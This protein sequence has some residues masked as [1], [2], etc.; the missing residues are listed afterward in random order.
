M[1]EPHGRHRR[2]ET[3]VGA[4]DVLATSSPAEHTGP[5]HSAAPRVRRS[6]WDRRRDRV[7]AALLVVAW[8]AAGVL[9]WTFSDSRATTQET[10][11]PPPALPP[12][13]E[14][15]PDD[16]AEVWRAPSDATPVPVAEDSAVVAASD[17]EV[18]G[19]DPLTGEVRWR[20]A[21]DLQLCTVAGAWSKAVAVYRKD[22]GCSEVTQ[23]D[24]A[25]G[26]RTAQRNGDAELGT[27][28]VVGEGHVT[29]TGERLLNTWRD[30][31][32][33]SMEYGRVPA[34]VNPDRQP[35]TGCV[36]DSVAAGAGKVGVVESCPRETG[37]RLTV[38]KA[39]GE[40]A[41]EPESEF[42]TVL[43]ERGAQLVAMS[44]D[45][46]AVA[47]P[48]R[49]RLVVYDAEG[50]Q[51]A[52]YPLEVPDSDLTANPP[53][54]VAPTAKGIENVYWF[55]GSSTV[56]LSRAD[57]AP[58]WTLEGTLGPGTVFGKQIVV[59]V[60]SGLA[61]LDEL[62]GDTAGTVAVDRRG[63]AG[64]VRLNAIGPVLLEQRGG[65]LVALR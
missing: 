31:L 65:T 21:R 33:K 2:A 25:T 8:V 59:P 40:N 63:Y 52:A 49:D 54:R 14:S 23:L 22:T 41:D 24:P 28:L 1:N 46:T 4:E 10:A 16:L 39:A 56:A 35:R 47:L 19:R 32:V 44:G 51:H 9:V 48:E 18:T 38:L 36:Y 11:A 45:F 58:R 5:R 29:A 6:P 61:V 37:D 57:L 3:G 30:D 20:Y 50:I 27:R 34:K 62:T 7:L 17:G 64:P 60:E 55:T 53:G 15:V 13:P 42:S 26:H 43:P 12:A